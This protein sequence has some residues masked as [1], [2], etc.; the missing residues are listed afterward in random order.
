M[1]REES[2]K[3]YALI[4]STMASFIAPFMGNAV[5]LA[6][7]SIGEEFNS[8]AVLLSWVVSCYLLTSAALLLPFGRLGDI[9]GRKR[10]FTIGLVVFCAATLLCGSAWSTQSLIF[11]RVL[12][13]I[14][15]AMNFSTNIA[16]LTA[17]Y[18]AR[19][20]GKVL[21]ISTAATY[22]GLSLGPVVGGVL[23]QRLGWESIFYFVFLI[24]IA[25]L[26]LTATKLKGEWIGAGGERFDKTGAFLFM[27]GMVAFIYGFS[28][29]ATFSPAKY[30]LVFGL[31]VM[32]VFVKHELKTEQP[33]LNMRFFSENVAFAFSNLAALINYC[34]TFA[35]TFLLSLFL[36]VVKGYGS[37]MAGLILLSQPILMAVL[38]P[39]AGALSDRVE[40]R[41]VSSW[42]MSLTTLGLVFFAFIDSDTQVWLLVI[43][44]MLL[45]TGF[46]LF[47]SPNTSAVMGSVA[48]QFYGVASSTLGTMRL[49]GQAVSM[50][51]A[52]L[53]IDLYIGS[54]QLGPA[55]AGLLAKS[56]KVSFIVFAATCFFGIFASLARGNVNQTAS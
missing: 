24:G 46:A 44:L 42:G 25:A 41:I 48:K 19:E 50:A 31:A 39:F 6:I 33:I 40:P 8:S 11:F 38:S 13:G 37:E 49:A 26:Y 21:G 14:G 56:V 7:P 4:I 51:A 23:N 22:T 3:K 29:I 55:V 52:T 20:R 27:V 17:V 9:I 10:L 35:V 34:A 43:N 5:N 18:P 36:Q 12:Q 47:S 2:L 53:I 15:S 45:G 1:D 32:A 16:I 28:S 54:A 30:I